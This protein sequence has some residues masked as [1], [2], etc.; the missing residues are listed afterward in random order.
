MILVKVLGLRRD[1]L[2]ERHPDTIESM[3]DLAIA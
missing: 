2:G 3:A 1:I